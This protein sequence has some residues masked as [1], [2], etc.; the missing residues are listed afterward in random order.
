[1]KKINSNRYGDRIIGLAALFLVPIPLCFYLLG[2]L[3]REIFRVWIYYSLAAG[4]FILLSF[5]VL[6]SIEFYQDR[7]IERKYADVR[8]K[9]VL[10][11]NG[12]YECQSCGNRKVDFMDNSCSVCGIVFNTDSEKSLGKELWIIKQENGQNK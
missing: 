3:F 9:K 12:V 10:L 8:K 4:L 5:S 2:L 7:M 6:L 11:G 1:M